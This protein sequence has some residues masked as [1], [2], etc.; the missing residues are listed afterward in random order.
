MEACDHRE[1]A[2]A[3]HNIVNS[4]LAIGAC[5]RDDGPSVFSDI[6]SSLGRY[7]IKLSVFPQ[8]FAEEPAGDM[9]PT[10]GW[11]TGGT[12]Y[13]DLFELSVKRTYK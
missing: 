1:P 3:S 8:R 2:N 5:W 9:E 7:G 11:R 6:G 4:M 10:G 13:P 12:M